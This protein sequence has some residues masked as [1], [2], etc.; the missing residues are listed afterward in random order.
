MDT[1][2]RRVVAR[3]YVR[4]APSGARL[5]IGNEGGGAL[6]PDNI[7]ITRDFGREDIRLYGVADLHIGAGEFMEREW[8]AFRRMILDDPHAY[9]V[10]A[11]DMINNGIKSS[12]TNTYAETMRPREQKK[13]ML[14]EL[15][16]LRDRIICG[17]P[18]N[19]EYRSDKEVDANP[20]YDVFVKLDLEN[21]YRE[22]AAFVTLHF[23]DRAAGSR[24]NPTYNLAVL[25]GCGGGLYI[26][27]GANRNQRYA[28]VI[29]G[30]DMLI[31]AHNH[32]PFT[33]PDAKLVFDSRNGRVVRRQ[34]A[35][36]S[37]TS[38]L[39]YGGYAPR[40]MMLPTPH[41]VEWALLGGG[42]KEIT[43][44]IKAV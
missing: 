7:S 14:E 26:G 42:K 28:A 31:T 44:A 29:E 18:G 13:R 11:G 22:N 9:L 2:P 37:C 38:W 10:V 39:D 3:V 1:C 36:M 32:K 40:K 4:R 21:V 16:P 33:F 6:I 34:Y 12:V 43:T 30:I 19:H 20:L 8:A 5:S 23:G 25:H 15:T 17:V 27:A 24:L 35:V 41:A